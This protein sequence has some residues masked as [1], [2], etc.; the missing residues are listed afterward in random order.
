[1][2][3]YI[4]RE[5]EREH[6]M[7]V[8]WTCYYHTQYANDHMQCM[9]ENKITYYDQAHTI[10]YDCTQNILYPLKVHIMTVY[11]GVCI[12]HYER[13]N[14]CIH[15][16]RYKHSFIYIW[17]KYVIIIHNT[18]YKHSLYVIIIHSKLRPCVTPTPPY[19][20]YDNY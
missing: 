14:F 9:I 20:D 13:T 12:I 11:M 1:M 4:Y 19:N 6:I 3:I 16:T 18:R 5:M 10:Y 2:T 15:S 8:Y 17:L 7:N